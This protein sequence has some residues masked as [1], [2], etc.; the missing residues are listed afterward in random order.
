M[1]GV[2][3][4]RGGTGD[5]SRHRRGRRATTSTDG[6]LAQL[7]ALVLS[8]TSYALTVG[9]AQ[10]WSR[11]INSVVRGEVTSAT[12]YARQLLAAC[13]LSLAAAASHQM[14][15]ARNKERLKTNRTYKVFPAYILSIKPD[16]EE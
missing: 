2:A 12:A 15:S 16:F 9:C 13:Q 1:V 4:A 6:H 11:N 8:Q 7:G 5:V 10:R 3:A 14:P